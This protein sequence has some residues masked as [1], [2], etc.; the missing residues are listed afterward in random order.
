VYEGT[1][2]PVS[3]TAE[4]LVGQLGSREM[5]GSYYTL[6][7]ENNYMIWT[8]LKSCHERGWV[9][10]G[11]DAM[12]WCP[13]CST[14]IS[15]HE[16]VTEGYKELTHTSVYVKYPLREHEGSLLI[17]TTTPWTL[18]SNVAV[19]VHPELDY[20]KIKFEG[21][22]LYLSK[23]T[24]SSALQK[25]EYE[26]LEEFKGADLEGWTY[27][28][29]FDDLELPREMGAHEAHRVIFWKEVGEDEGTGIVHIAPGAGKEDLELGK[30]YG[31]PI[32][33]PLD[34]YGVFIDGLG[35]PCL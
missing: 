34:E 20:V 13:R 33:A 9:Y 25:K 1:H 16:I 10:K 23:V 6:S 8:V 2:G 15:Q 19:A 29:P 18:T 22:I 32:V 28:G 31:L 35:W 5:G 17:W 14:G 30:L 11:A 12:P 27:D 3:G 7:D 21:D 26:L 4:Y 24:V